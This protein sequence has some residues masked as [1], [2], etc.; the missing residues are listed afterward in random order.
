MQWAGNSSQALFEQISLRWDWK[1]ISWACGPWIHQSG[2]DKVGRRGEAKDSIFSGTRRWDSDLQHAASSKQRICCRM[3]QAHVSEISWSND[4]CGMTHLPWQGN[5]N[6]ELQPAAHLQYVQ[7]LIVPQGRGGL[8]IKCHH[9]IC[10]ML[11][12]RIETGVFPH[13]H[14]LCLTDNA[15]PI[16]GTENWLQWQLCWYSLAWLFWDTT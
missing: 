13:L 8:T 16:V 3:L 6:S 10:C 9:S 12:R 14:F 4:S 1:H 5:E 7:S 2:D 11:N 15:V